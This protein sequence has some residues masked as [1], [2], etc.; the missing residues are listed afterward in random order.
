MKETVSHIHKED[1]MN[2][3]LHNQVNVTDEKATR[4][5]HFYTQESRQNFSESNGRQLY[6]WMK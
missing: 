6:G 3:R 5:L 2:M 1:S 4:M